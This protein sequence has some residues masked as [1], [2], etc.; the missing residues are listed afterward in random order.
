MARFKKYVKDDY[1]IRYM[2]EDDGFE[3]FTIGKR[4][5]GGIMDCGSCGTAEEVKAIVGGKPKLVGHCDIEYVG[6]YNRPVQ[7]NVV[8]NCW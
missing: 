3:Y 7:K 6:V 2:K 1:I 4:W 5:A 8:G